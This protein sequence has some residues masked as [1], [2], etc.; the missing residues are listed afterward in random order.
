MSS[1]PPSPTTDGTPT[2]EIARLFPVQGQWTESDYFGLS[3][4]R[5]VELADGRLEILPMPTWMHQMIIDFIAS[6]MRRASE[7]K[8]DGA[9][10]LQAPLPVTLFPGTIRE[11]D[12]LYLTPNCFPKSPHEYP[13]RLD[14]AVEVVSEG[15]E[16]RHRDYVAKRRDYAIGGVQEYWIVDPFERH[17]TVLELGSGNYNE[18][19]VFQSGEIAR[20]NFNRF[21]E[22]PVSDVMRLVDDV[23]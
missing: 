19:G 16:S 9:R 13:S 20:G 7:K 17:V 11:P 18:L 6:L 23:V 21:I 10:V 4:D 2:W 22:L 8:S 12:I 15:T 1:I 5:M 14:I 3:T